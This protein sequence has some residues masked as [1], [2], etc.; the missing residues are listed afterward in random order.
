MAAPAAEYEVEK[1]PTSSGM[2]G[3]PE[4]NRDWR[5]RE[6]TASTGIT[7]TAESYPDADVDE[8][9]ATTVVD[10]EETGTT[11]VDAVVGARVIVS[12]VECEQKKC[13]KCWRP[14]ERC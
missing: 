12:R 10:A 13:E 5:R 2:P 14:A 9:K 8:D 4:P 7:D 11:T 1:A 6:T 3:S